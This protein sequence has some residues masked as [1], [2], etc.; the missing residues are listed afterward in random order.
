MIFTTPH[1][2]S[3]QD[4]MRKPENN[5]LSI[6]EATR[7]YREQLLLFEQQYSTFIQQQQMVLQK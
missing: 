5:K 1:P 6:Q 3:W 4:F 7:K 2:G